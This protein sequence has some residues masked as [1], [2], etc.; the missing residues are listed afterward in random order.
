[1]SA[2]Y[3]IMATGL[4]AGS[5]TTVAVMIFATLER[6]SPFF[7]VNAISHMAFGDK[8]FVSRPSSKFSTTGLILNLVAIISWAAVQE[9]LFWLTGW[10]SHSLAYAWLAALIVTAVAYVVDFYIVPKRLTPGFE[11][12]LSRRSL[13]FTYLV[14]AL[15]LAVGALMRL[16]Y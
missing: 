1:M 4:V 12:V 8:A 10:P 13:Y 14:L 3:N 5:L 11:R 6:K 2:I 9:G 7:P 15:G 16:P